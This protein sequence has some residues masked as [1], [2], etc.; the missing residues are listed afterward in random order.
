VV[1]SGGQ[2]NTGGGTLLLHPGTSPAAVKPTKSGID[3]TASTL[4]FASDLAIAIN[5]TTV[6]TQYNQLNVVGQVNLTGVDLKLSGSHTPLPGQQFMIVNN[7]GTS[8]PI[9]GT[10]NGLPEG[11]AI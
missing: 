9:I 6:D 8:D 1:I 10:F 5:G 11:A 2:V 7:D 3:V 4:S